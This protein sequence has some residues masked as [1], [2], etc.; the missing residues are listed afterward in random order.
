MFAGDGLCRSRFSEH[1]FEWIFSG[2]VNDRLRLFLEQLL[3]L[4]ID[5]GAC[6]NTR[7]RLKD[8]YRSVSHLDCFPGSLDV[9]P[10]TQN[11]DA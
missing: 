11:D 4:A 1:T 10:A 3:C 5:S 8:A 6:A 9:S 2:T 7:C